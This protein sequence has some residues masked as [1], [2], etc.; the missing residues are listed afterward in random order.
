MYPQTT[1]KT[2]ST[3]TLHPSLKSW[4]LGVKA[5]LGHL[6]PYYAGRNHGLVGTLEGRCPAQVRSGESVSAGERTRVFPQVT[7]QLGGRFKT[8]AEEAGIPPA[9]PHTH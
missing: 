1:H 2:M 3:P 6:Y 4:S 7:K 9:A 8:L 5:G